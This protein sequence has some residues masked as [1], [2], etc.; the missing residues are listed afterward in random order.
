MSLFE[1]S[2]HLALEDR[3]SSLDAPLLLPL[4]PNLPYSEDVPEDLLMYVHQALEEVHDIIAG[5]LIETSAFLSY[6][7]LGFASLEAIFGMLHELDIP[8][9]ADA[10]ACF[11]LAGVRGVLRSFCQPDSVFRA[12]ALRVLCSN[13]SLRDELCTH[14]KTAFF[15]ADHH[16]F[17]HS[18]DTEAR[19]QH[20]EAF[21]LFDGLASS[22]L[23]RRDGTGVLHVARTM[24]EMIWAEREEGAIRRA[25]VD[26]SKEFL[27]LR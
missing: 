3:I 6:G 4:S 9:V 13:S 12:H 10:P 11:S 25:F 24:D 15:F 20:P 26:C 17:I 18:S 21:L 23:R 14:A 1:Q 19:R 7:S 2:F 8:I 5:V 22:Q 27:S 16:D